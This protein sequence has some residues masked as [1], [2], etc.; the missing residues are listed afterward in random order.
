MVQVISASQV[1]WQE[2]GSEEEAALN[3]RHCSPECEH[4]K[5]CLPKCAT[6]PLPPNAYIL[7]LAILYSVYLLLPMNS[8][9]MCFLIYFVPP[10]L[11]LC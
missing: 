3:P 1:H 6:M 8:K 5:L 11:V 9:H 2:A 7:V 10:I 4:T